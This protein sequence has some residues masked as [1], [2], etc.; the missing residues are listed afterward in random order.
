MPHKPALACFLIT[1]VGNS[2]FKG[3][4]FEMNEFISISKRIHQPVS[5][6]SDFTAT[7]TLS[8]IAG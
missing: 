8:K 1:V 6:L 3:V 5:K 4:P 2:F 7:H